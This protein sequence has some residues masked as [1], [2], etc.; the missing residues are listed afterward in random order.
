MRFLVALLIALIPSFS[1][2]QTPVYTSAKQAYL[3][4]INTQT[5]LLGRGEENR[6]PTS[7]MSKMMTIYMVFDALKSNKI[8]L[9]DDFTV[10]EKAWRMEGS[11]SFMNINSK[12]KV[13]DLIRGVIIQS[14]NDA[15]MI[16]AEG[17][18]GSE[19]AFMAASNE[20]AQAIGMKNSHF[21]NPSGLPEPEHYSTPQDLALLAWHL[22]YDFPEY[23]HYF[24]EKEF[25]FN[26]IKQGNR[27]PLLYRNIGA[28][29]LKTGH[30]DEAGYGITASAI[31]NG[32]RLILVVNGLA[33]M[34][35]RADESARL[36]NFGFDEFSLVTLAKKDEAV[37]EIK[38]AFGEKKTIS[39]TVMA[40][41]VV[42][43]RNAERSKVKTQLE[44]S[45]RIEAP[46]AKGTEIG[47]L[48][49]VL[50]DTVLATAPLV[51]GDNVNK[52]G[53][54]PLMWAKLCFMITGKY[55]E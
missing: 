30:A 7:S 25:M 3:I 34:Q 15:A 53:F 42:T 32:R 22:I 29:G 39:V 52:L 54:F 17:L 38:I 4:D 48:N 31:R 37:R 23:Y 9:N 6:M 55:D 28:D 19:S 21:V 11:R 36:I 16:L 26:N 5:V 43:V 8:S 14:G 2:A 40:D 41:V 33:N 18:S 10:S 45:E 13:E 20:K 50:G 49:V 27:N 24:G 12:V 44:L 47:K 35:E 1:V 51:A 46:V